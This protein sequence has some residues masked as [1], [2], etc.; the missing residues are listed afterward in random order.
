MK[1][2]WLLTII[3]C[4]AGLFVLFFTLVGASGAPQ[5]AAGAAIAIA[6]AVIPYCLARS[7]QLRS[8]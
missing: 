2:L 1:F 6:F 8:K 5:E 4:V 7:V 3:G